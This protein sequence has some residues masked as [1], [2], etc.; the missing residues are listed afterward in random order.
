ME[1]RPVPRQA[2]ADLCGKIETLTGPIHCIDFETSR[3]ALLYH[4]GMRPYGLVTFQ[5]IAH[6]ALR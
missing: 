1:R 5:W 3:L 2:R 6:T 4:R